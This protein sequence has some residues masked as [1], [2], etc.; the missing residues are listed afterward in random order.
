MIY[1]VS[2]QYNLYDSSL[3]ESISLDDSIELLRKFP[4]LGLDTETEGLDS[5]TKK[6]L[7]LQ[8]GTYEV[9]V[10]F[11]IASFEGRIPE[12]L[13]MFLNETESLFIMQTAK[14]DLQFLFQQ[15]I[16]I[17]KVYDTML[18]E[19][20]LTNGLQY[21]GRDLATL[22]VKYCGARVDKS[23]RGEIIT[24][25]LSSRVL[26]YGADDIKYLPKI[27]EA[28]L[29]EIKKNNLQVAVDLDNSFVVVLAYI[30]FCGIKLDYEKWRIKTKKNIEE[31]VRLKDALE[32]QLRADGK[33]KYFS[34]MVNLWTG[35]RDCDINW[36]SPKQVTELFIDYG[37]NVTIKK[38]G[39][40]KI[41]ID[42]KVLD[43]QKDKFS[44]IKPYLEYK[45][46]QKEVST[47]GYKWKNYI[48]PVTGRI[49]TSY[50]QLM[51]TSRLSSGD[52]REGKPNMQNI[53]A[54]HETRSCFIPEKGNVM[55]DADYSGQETIVLAN[56]SK[57][58]GLI[59]FYRRGFTDM[60][61]YIAFLMYKNIRPC[62]LEDISKETLKYIENNYPDKRQIAKK[63]GF[64]IA[65]GGNGSTIARNCNIPKKDGEFVYNSYFESFPVMKKYF[66]MVFNRASHFGYIEFN[67]V[68]KRK[69]FFDV[70]KNDYFT[71]KD[72]VN[73][74]YFRVSHPNP[75]EA[76]KRFNSAKSDIQRIAQNYPKMYGALYS[77]VY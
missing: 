75:G 5:F 37:I 61:S 15:E 41:S 71:L 47:Y 55:I 30:E 16:I 28:Q 77:N 22:T 54:E 52:K 2:N 48:N 25:G 40:E 11:D 60:H 69:Y 43:P 64:A 31:V 12:K 26:A 39:E 1:L 67:K 72:E 50:K 53:P 3:F 66:D 63:A 7:L 46:K 23:V 36:D 38:K 18:A 34:R 44:I 8:I 6:L 10:L 51:D 59:E 27:K 49:H 76:M 45:E 74:R 62:A 35:K 19:T 20:I 24:K 56:H 9:Q 29:I 68:T 73:D 42:A 4:E 58:P 57:E 70:D 21:G 13:V 17:R 65:Y 14:F 32:D 33:L